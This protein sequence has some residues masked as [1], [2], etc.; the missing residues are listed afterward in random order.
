MILKD[1]WRTNHRGMGKPLELYSEVSRD[2]KLVYH[3]KIFLGW[4]EYS[5][6]I[7]MLRHEDHFIK[8]IVFH[9][10]QRWWTVHTRTH[11]VHRMAKLRSRGEVKFM[12]STIIVPYLVWVEQYMALTQKETLPSTNCHNGSRKGHF[13]I[14]CRLRTVSCLIGTRV[15]IH[16]EGRFFHKNPHSRATTRWIVR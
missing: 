4:V 12:S 9:P 15:V 1:H 13:W 6:D 7:L 11:E 8:K 16:L 14:T 5:V 10:R 2:G 3:S